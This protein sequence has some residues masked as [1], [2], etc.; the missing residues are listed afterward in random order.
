MSGFAAECYAPNAV[1]RILDDQQRVVELVNNYAQ[2]SFNFGPTLLSWMEE[3]APKVYE[4]IQQA[5]KLS[6]E[7]FSG[8]ARLWRK[9]TIT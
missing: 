1:S 4:S 2:M 5:D 3:K 9:P 6:R 8:M 7:K